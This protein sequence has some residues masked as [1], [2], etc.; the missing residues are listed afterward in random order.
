ME[1]NAIAS[2]SSGNCYNIKDGQTS[3]LIEAGIPI[4]E[5]Q[6]GLD[7][8]LGEVAGC[9]VS[10]QHRDHCKAIRDLIARG[11]DVY[12]PAEVFAAEK[13]TGNR[14]HPAQ[15]E[16][17]FRIGTFTIYPFAGKHDVTNY[18]YIV[19]S[20]A[21]QERLLFFTDTYYLPQLFPKMDYIMGEAN[22]SL[23]A[24]NESIEA[25]LL[26]SS[27]KSRLIESH[28]S[29][30][31]FIE[32]LKANDKSKLKKVFLLHLSSNNSREAE[33]KERVQIETGVEVYVC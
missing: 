33:F 7:F 30:D 13:A 25:G 16:S 14:C 1:I 27:L 28:M 20:K 18:G 8:K 15:P 4:K 31:N 10:H 6:K 5:I 11:I 23:E 21:T 22:Y 3:L 2:G 32:L 29:I 24:I 17:S 9:I 19:Y 26:P 12:A